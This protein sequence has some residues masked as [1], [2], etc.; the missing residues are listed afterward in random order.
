MINWNPMQHVTDRILDYLDD[1][2]S[3]EA[4]ADFESHVA[5]CGSCR[6]TLGAT[7]DLTLDLWQAGRI[8]KGWPIDLS[9]H[10]H[11]VRSRTKYPVQVG[12]RHRPR[13]LSWQM[14]LSVAL[15]AMAVASGISLNPAKADGPS[16]PSIQT[17]GTDAVS[18][19]DTPTRVVAHQAAPQTPTVTLTPYK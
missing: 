8:L 7:R 6:V 18:Y 5:N 2:L 15:A 12:N 13:Q 11:I 17:P 19:S 9:R 16:I 14:S 10:W 3:P 4:R 1:R